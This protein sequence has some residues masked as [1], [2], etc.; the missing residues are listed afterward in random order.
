ML[1]LNSW[2]VAVKVSFSRAKQIIID[3]IQ[4]LLLKLNSLFCGF[5]LVSFGTDWK[6]I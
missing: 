3:L 4:D 2:W 6:S 5:G 1:L